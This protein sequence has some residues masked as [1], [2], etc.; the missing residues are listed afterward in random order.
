MVTAFFDL[1]QPSLPECHIRSRPGG[2]G[3]NVARRPEVDGRQADFFGAPAPAVPE[4]RPTPEPNPEQKLKRQLPPPDCE[5]APVS[6]SIDGLAAR[7]SPSE[8][9]EL[10]AALPD[11]ALAHLVIA[12][13]RQLRRRLARSSGRGGKSRAASLER[14]ARQLI[15]E[16]GGQDGDDEGWS[17]D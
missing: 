9:N 15:A 8:L 3:R 6:G 10:V 17:A 14:A 1:V 4:Q 12:T 2:K 13:A 16:L 5:D 11:D 7:L